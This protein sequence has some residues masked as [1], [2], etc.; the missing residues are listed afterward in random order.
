MVR[1]IAEVVYMG[2]FDAQLILDEAMQVLHIGLFVVTAG[3]P[4]L[5]RD[6]EHKPAGIVELAHSCSCAVDPAE[7]LDTADVAIVVIENTVAIKEDR[8][9]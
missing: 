4:G 8:R 7:A 3:D 9:P 5:V 2:T 1:T 6:D